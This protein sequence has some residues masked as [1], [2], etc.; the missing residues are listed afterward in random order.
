MDNLAFRNQLLAIEPEAIG[1]E[2]EGAGLYL[3]AHDAQV[4]WMLVKA[5]C[6]W[7]DGNKG[8]DKAARQAL[9]AQNAATF[10]LHTIAQ[11]G[12]GPES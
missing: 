6:D 11:G 7:A 9:A 1:G 4:P 10:T 3:A 8:E 12:F 2:M 5:I